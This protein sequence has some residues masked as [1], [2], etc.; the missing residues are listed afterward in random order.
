MVDFG[1]APTQCFRLD[2]AIALPSPP[3][4]DHAL[5]CFDRPTGAPALTEIQRPEATDQTIAREI[6]NDVRPEDLQI[7]QDKG[8]VVG[9]PGPAAPGG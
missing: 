9:A 3:Y 7:P 6:R 4:G 1:D 8:A 5:F 2:L